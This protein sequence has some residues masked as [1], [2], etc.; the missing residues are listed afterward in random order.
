[1]LISYENQHSNNGLYAIRINW[2][3]LFADGGDTDESRRL[4]KMWTNWASESQEEDY[5]FGNFFS[6][7]IRTDPQARKFWERVMSRTQSQADKGQ[8]SWI[9][10]VFRRGSD[11][12]TEEEVD[13]GNE[14]GASKFFNSILSRFRGQQQAKQEESRNIPQVELNINNPAAAA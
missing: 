11:G 9:V 1:M 2:T 5:K 7:M 12:K 4:K 8:G 10:K 6:S 3:V 13:Q 14:G